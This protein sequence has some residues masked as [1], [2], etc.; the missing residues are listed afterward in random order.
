[1]VTGKSKPVSQTS[2]RLPGIGQQH[3]T[4]PCHMG[5]GWDTQN[6]NC[7]IMSE[8]EL[9]TVQVLQANYVFESW[10]IIFCVI[11]HVRVFG[12]A[13]AC[14]QRVKHLG[15]ILTSHLS[16]DKVIMHQTSMYNRKA[17]AVL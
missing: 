2:V 1:M 7:Q 15:H 6:V 9:W 5:I 12:C 16:D 4:V 11:A 3:T 14:V 10:E 8:L 17:N 13:R